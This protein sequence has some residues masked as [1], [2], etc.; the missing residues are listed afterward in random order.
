MRSFRSMRVL[1]AALM[2]AAMSVN[3]FADARKFGY[4][5]EVETMPL[6]MVE[7][8]QWITWKASKQSDSK[9]DSLE[10]RHELEFAITENLQVG[11]YFADWRYQDGRS[12]EHDKA[13]YKNSAVE[14]IYNLSDPVTDSIG[15]ALYG[16]IKLGDQLF[17]LEGKLLLQKNIGKWVFAYNLIMEAEWEHDRYADDKGEFGQTFGISYEVTPE[18]LVG[19][20]ATHEVEFDDWEHTGPSVFYLGPNMSYRTKDSWWITI[21]PMFQLTDIEDEPEFQTRF[22]FGFFF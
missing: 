12:V 20:E 8:E 1:F 9:F 2:M 3:V 7:Y 15:S 6:G 19:V 10:F 13:E 4:V 18:F 14:F 22:L 5:Y 17:E 11:L 16:E 21:T